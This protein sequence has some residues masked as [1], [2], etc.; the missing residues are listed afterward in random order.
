MDPRLVSFTVDEATAGHRVD[1]AV[2][3]AGGLTRSQA[4]RLARAG[5]VLVNGH[6][7]VPGRRLEAGDRVEAT[8]PPESPPSAPAAEP[9]ALAVLFED[10]SI[11]VL[12]KPQGLAV[13]PGAGRSSGTLVNALLAHCPQLAAGS[14]SFRPGLVHRLDKDTS[15]LM[16]VAK[17]DAAYAELTRQVRAREIER[18]YLAVVWGRLDTDQ[19]LIDVPIARHPRNRLRMAAVPRSDGHPARP[20]TTEVTVIERGRAFTLVEARLQTGRTHQIRVHLAHIGHPVV[21][22]PVY[23]AR[24]GRRRLPLLEVE[25]RQLVEV[26]PGQALHAHGLA[27][28]HPETGQRMAF[29]A[30]APGVMMQLLARLRK[31]AD[32]QEK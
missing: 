21:G 23:A 7:S 4:E 6:P 22:D 26:L 11:I 27:F 24:V 25:T 12:N 20:A 15:G 28:Q 19:V 3:V 16:V 1:A 18:R 29:S 9:I 14:A 10:A 13:H 32:R 5:A 30:P 8:I 31:P 17:T 2:A